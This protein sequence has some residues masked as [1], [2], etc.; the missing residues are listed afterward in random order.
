MSHHH[1]DMLEKDK[2]LSN[3]FLWT[4]PRGGTNASTVIVIRMDTVTRFQILDKV[5]FIS[6]STNTFGKGMNAH[7]F[8]PAICKI[9]G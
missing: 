9:V 5:V 3:V 2:L 6:R 1:K 4:P 8:P 7:I